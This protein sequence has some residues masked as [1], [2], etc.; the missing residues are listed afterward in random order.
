MEKSQARQATN[1]QPT[2][3]RW[4]CDSHPEVNAENPRQQ[5]N[6]MGGTTWG[7]FRSHVHIGTIN[8]RSCT[9]DEVN[10]SEDYEEIDIKQE[11][12]KEWDVLKK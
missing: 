7:K 5:Y 6:Q 3:V 10:Y 12:L 9:K 2:K 1:L 11:M 8:M 4:V